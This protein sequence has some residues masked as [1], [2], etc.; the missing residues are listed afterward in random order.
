MLGRG[1]EMKT[2]SDQNE[3]LM[4]RVFSLERENP[5]I[6]ALLVMFALMAAFSIVAF[7]AVLHADKVC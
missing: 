5:G 2:S 7:A 6:W 1:E 4:K 3:P